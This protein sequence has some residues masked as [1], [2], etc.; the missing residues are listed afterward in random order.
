M[1]FNLFYW[2]QSFLFFK[3]N[4][5][6][7]CGLHTTTALIKAANTSH[8]IVKS[9]VSE[10]YLMNLQHFFFKHLAFSA[11]LHPYI[12]IGN[13]NITIYPSIHP[14]LTTAWRTSLIE[15]LYG[16]ILRCLTIRILSLW[17]DLLQWTRAQLHA[18][19]A[20]EVKK[21]EPQ[22]EHALLTEASRL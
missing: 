13:G 5:S 17:S 4:H 1:E 9:P 18:W 2:A 11:N 8:S 6:G 19:L 3:E 10:I 15:S 20:C 22:N 12:I 14:L 21:A 16:R 7:P